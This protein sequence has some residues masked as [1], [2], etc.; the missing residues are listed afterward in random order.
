MSSQL[1]WAESP[2]L[3]LAPPP[4]S[5]LSKRKLELWKEITEEVGWKVLESRSY[6]RERKFAELPPELPYYSTY[7][8]LC[9]FSQLAAYCNESLASLNCGSCSNLSA[10]LFKGGPSRFQPL[11]A[12]GEN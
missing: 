1:W 2:W 9:V 7:R 10:P 11:S 12:R 3:S 5:R 4:A 6:Q 8:A